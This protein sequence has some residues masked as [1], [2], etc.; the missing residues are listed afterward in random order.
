MKPLSSEPLVSVIVAS[1]NQGN[2]I[3]E[4]I[5]SAL[6]QDYK[7]LELLIIDAAS[8][9]S[10]LQ[11]LKKY[12]R[13]PR[14]RWIS[15]PDNGPNDAFNKGL[16]MAKGEIVSLQTTSDLYL[17]GA[18]R[19][20]VEEFQNPSLAFVGGSMKISDEEGRTTGEVW[21]FQER[22]RFTLNEI[23]SLK[24]YPGMPATFFRRDI[25]LAIGGMDKKR[26]ICH[27]IFFLNY[28]IESFKEGGC[29]IALP[30]FWAV[31]RQHRNHRN[32]RPELKGL[33][34]AQE[35][36]EACHLYADR[37]QNFLSQDQINLLLRSAYFSEAERRWT[38]L[39]Q[40]FLM[41]LPLL[42]ALRYRATFAEYREFF[43]KIL[44]RIKTKL[45][46]KGDLIGESGLD[47]RWYLPSQKEN[48]V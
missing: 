22:F 7:N 42:K 41:F 35:R 26:Q 13:D 48:N 40:R 9:D 23:L 38:L 47:L 29:A 18:I 4:T 11:V 17:Q 10:T 14:L 33:S 37:Y 39:G 30:D 31:F 6:K 12:E 36:H 8:T 15:E 20:A 32:K 2:Y 21:K 25:A 19:A 28:L 45:F 1:Y 24:K 5:L 46:K 44:L 27:S 16:Q 3:E 34:Y 43:G